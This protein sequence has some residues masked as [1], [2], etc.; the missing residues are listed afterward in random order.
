[1][2]RPVRPRILDEE[3]H[4]YLKLMDNA[5]VE[6]A[7]IALPCLPETGPVPSSFQQK[8]AGGTLEE[9]DDAVSEPLAAAYVPPITL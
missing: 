5:E 6:P 1:M 4:K 2:V 9:D 3:F 8:R 7:S